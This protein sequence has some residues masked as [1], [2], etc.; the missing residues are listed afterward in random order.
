MFNDSLILLDAIR[1]EQA[2]RAQERRRRLEQL[3]LIASDTPAP[4]KNRRR[5]VL[6]LLRPRLREV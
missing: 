5:P 3:R 4:A 1:M 6:R 2:L